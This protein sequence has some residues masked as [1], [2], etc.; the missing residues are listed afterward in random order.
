MFKRL[1]SGSRMT[2]ECPVRF[3]EGLS[4]KFRGSTH[5]KI[6]MSSILL[7]SVALNFAAKVTMHNDT[8]A[9]Y[10]ILVNDKGYLLDTDH[11]V[12]MDVPQEGWL[13]YVWSGPGI[14]LFK[15]IDDGKFIHTFSVKPKVKG[16]ELITIFVGDVVR[17]ARGQ[18]APFSVTTSKRI[19]VK[20]PKTKKVKVQGQ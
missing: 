15:K 19:V 1:F 13:N 16:D 4:G 9:T 5:Q 10:F 12:T 17:E 14:L 11:E 18:R 8:K 20:R 2:R 7:S 3:C 6:L